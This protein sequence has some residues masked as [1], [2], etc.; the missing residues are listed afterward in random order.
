M[1][2]CQSN[3]TDDL[4]QKIKSGTVSKVL[5]GYDFQRRFERITDGNLP[6]FEQVGSTHMYSGIDL[7]DYDEGMSLEAKVE[8][9]NKIKVELEQ[10][11]VQ[12]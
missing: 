3:F 7:G 2:Q 10:K 5:R 12:V 11:Q 1:Q 9:Y 4:I 8:L 6:D